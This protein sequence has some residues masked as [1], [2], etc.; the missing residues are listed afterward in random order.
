MAFDGT[1]SSKYYNDSGAGT[2]VII[3][4]GTNA[5]VTSLGLTTADDRVNRDPTSF[6][7]YGSNNGSSWT[8]IVDN[9]SLSPPES[10]KTNYPIASFGNNTA[11][12]Y[13]KLIFET[14]RKTNEALQV[15]E[16][17]L[18]GTFN[19]VERAVVGM[20]NLDDDTDATVNLTSSDLGEATVS[21][22]TLTFTEDNWNTARTVTVTGINDSDRDR[23]QPYRISLSAE[24]QF[25]NNP[26]VST[27]AGSGV[28][29][30]SNATGTSATF[31]Y[32][33]GITTDGTNLYVA[34]SENH[35]IR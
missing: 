19:T 7:L 2:G 31:K 22:T 10:R 32:P 11:Y 35:K 30:S 29:G 24:D 3:N 8:S 6:S 14:T 23:H 12:Q 25:S 16:I 18:G 13:F 33:W 15:S 17:R 20:D 5:T 1:T 34:D 26:E 21:P 27:F 9:A 28:A 4:T